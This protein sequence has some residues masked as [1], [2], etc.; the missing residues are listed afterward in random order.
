LRFATVAN[1]RVDVLTELAPGVALWQGSGGP[2]EPNAAVVID[3][4]GITVIDALVSPSQAAPF[5][6]ACTEVG[7]PVRRLVVTSSHAEYVGGSS[8]F[9]LAAVYGTAEISAL[10][11]LPP[12]VEGFRRLFPDHDSEFDELV[13]R[14]VSHTVT[15]A[16]WISA[17]A[18]AVPLPG[19][20]EQNLVV[21][22]PEQGVV[23][24]G[25]LASFTTTPLVFDGDPARWIESLDVIAGYGSIFVPG[26]GPPGDLRAIGDLQLYLQAVIDA[27]GDVS[28]LRPGPWKQWSGSQYHAVNVERAAML[29]AGNPA[30][31]PSM[32][33]LLGLA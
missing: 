27:G 8:M 30:P 20:L 5:A 23:V 26:H 10:L 2:G 9:P 6:Q 13:T 4:D 17:S 18:V 19:E 22:I 29:A 16:A 21:Q 11:D 32:L 3:D 1:V 24:C 15:E 7:V 31:P 28:A 33:R 25:A 14:P 12:N